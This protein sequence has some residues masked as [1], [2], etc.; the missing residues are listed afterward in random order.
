ML[1]MGRKGSE[2]PLE[3]KHRW[4]S[5]KRD[6]N[7]K[8]KDKATGKE[9]K[10]VSKADFLNPEK[11]WGWGGQ[12]QKWQREEVKEELEEESKEKEIPCQDSF[13]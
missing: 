13:D 5:R 3:G 4:K 12:Y 7:T 8:Q 11:R 2:V 9:E 6:I 1:R 10:T